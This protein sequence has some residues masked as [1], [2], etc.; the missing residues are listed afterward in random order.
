MKLHWQRRHTNNY[1]LL[2]ASFCA[3]AASELSTEL[4]LKVKRK[5]VKKVL[6]KIVDILLFTLTNS[7]KADIWGKQVIKRTMTFSN[8]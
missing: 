6:L 2:A 4:K 5:F 7:S 8:Q 1:L 3:M